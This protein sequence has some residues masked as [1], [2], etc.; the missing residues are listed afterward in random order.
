[1]QN[2]DKTLKM[3]PTNKIYPKTIVAKKKAYKLI[4]KSYSKSKAKPI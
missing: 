3:L 2:L 4:E 1:M